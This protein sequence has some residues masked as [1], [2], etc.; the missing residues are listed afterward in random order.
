MFYKHKRAPQ[1]ILVLVCRGVRWTSAVIVPD[2]GPAQVVLFDGE[3]GLDDDESGTFFQLREITKRTSAQKQ[4]SRIVDRQIA[5]L[6]DMLH[7]CKCLSA[8][9]HC[10]RKMVSHC[11]ATSQ[12]YVP[13]T[14]TDYASWRCRPWQR[15]QLTIACFVH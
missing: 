6:R 13:G 12:A 4:H 11:Q 8:F 10:C 14:P 5:V 3:T 9:L 2:T 1:L 7:T 15:E